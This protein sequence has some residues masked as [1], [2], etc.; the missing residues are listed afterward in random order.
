ME[1]IFVPNNLERL[2]FTKIF[3]MSIYIQNTCRFMRGNMKEKL[4]SLIIVRY[5]FLI[6]LKKFLFCIF[7]KLA[8]SYARISI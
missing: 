3:N 7:D 4:I 8:E 5:F 1:I 2:G 6:L